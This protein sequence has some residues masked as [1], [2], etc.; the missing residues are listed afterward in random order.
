MGRR[1]A[2]DH[3]TP[4]KLVTNPGGGSP[5]K[6]LYD[7]K[8]VPKVTAVSVENVVD[9]TRLKRTRIVI[10]LYGE[11]EVIRAPDGDA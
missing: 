11:T 10:D 3:R 1:M 4:F 6:L 2:D 9:G 5:A 8:L 7:G